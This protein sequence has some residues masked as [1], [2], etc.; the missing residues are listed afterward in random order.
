MW[1]ALVH[2]DD[3]SRLDALQNSRCNAVRIA[4]N[5][6]KTAYG[7]ADQ[8]HPALGE[9]WMNGG[10]LHSHRRPEILS[11]PKHGIAL[12]DFFGDHRRWQAPERGG[13]MCVRM[14]SNRVAAGDDR[15]HQMG[16][17]LRQSALEKECRIGTRLCEHLE[18]RR[19]VIGRAVVDR[20]PHLL[21]LCG[22]SSDHRSEPLHIG[23]QRGIEQQ[24]VRRGH[25]GQS[26]HRNMRPENDGHK[27]R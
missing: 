23:T 3:R 20:Q 9:Q 26:E 15:A 18:N 25:D 10:V 8:A 27:R 5:G 4:D 16:V 21:S 2:D 6:V 19:C 24:G 13:R 7:P 17:S 14:I 11:C 22:E 12:V 1:P